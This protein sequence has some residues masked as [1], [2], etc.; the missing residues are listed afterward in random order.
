M[1][2]RLA[3]AIS[4]A[5]GLM[6]VM[7]FTTTRDR[8]NICLLMSLDMRTSM[9]MATGATIRATGMSGFRIGWRWDGLLITPDTGT[10][11][12]RGDIRGSMTRRG[13]MLH[14]TM[15]VG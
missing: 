12:S 1:W 6:S 5:P 15:D 9:P 2:N 8:R 7:G 4:L 11:L 14:F 3:G 10:G 13:D